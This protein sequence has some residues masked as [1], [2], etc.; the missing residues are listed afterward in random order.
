M[1][2]DT[3]HTEDGFLLLGLLCHTRWFPLLIFGRTEINENRSAVNK[4]AGRDE[5]NRAP[6]MG[7]MV[8]GDDLGDQH[9]CQ[10]AGRVADGICDADQSSAERRTHVDV[11]QLV[12]DG[13]DSAH[14]EGQSE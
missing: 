14:R 7:L 2:V 1:P 5:E 11:G 4:H 6:L 9:W 12:S 13:R 3:S 8:F 10:N